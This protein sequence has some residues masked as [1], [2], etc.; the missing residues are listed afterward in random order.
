MDGLSMGDQGTREFEL[1]FLLIHAS[2]IFSLFSFFLVF[3]LLSYFFGGVG[4]NF[5]S[6]SIFI[7][8][9]DSVSNGGAPVV[10]CFVLF[11]FFLLFFC[12][13]G[14]GVFFPFLFSFL[15]FFLLS[16]LVFWERSSWL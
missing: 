15:S 6:F 10:S 3:F 12:S 16:D 13:V 14:R 11:S 9:L 4:V 5:Y 7:G 2:F 8:G 1:L